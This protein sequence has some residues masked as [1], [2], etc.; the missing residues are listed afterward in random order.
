MSTLTLDAEG[1][2]ALDRGDRRL[3]VLLARA[4]A[5]GERITVPTTALAHAIR[6]PS[7]Q[8]RLSRLIRQPNT[9]VAALSALDA[10]A[11]SILLATSKTSDIVD[12][13]VVICA[14]RLR[15]SIVT[16]DPDDR[17]RLDPD[18]AL[19]AV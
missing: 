2:I 1:S 16:S 11:V 19:I 10:T 4:A 12:A 18:A 13:H 8:V 7:T 14:R 17:R 6:R 9:G 15:G 5:L 3:L